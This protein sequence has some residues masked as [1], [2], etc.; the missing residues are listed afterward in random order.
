MDGSKQGGSRHEAL[1]L[2]RFGD[3][4]RSAQSL[5]S[6]ENP[7][8]PLMRTRHERREDPG[9]ML[10]PE[11]GE[12]PKLGSWVLPFTLNSMQHFSTESGHS[13]VKTQMPLIGLA[14]DSCDLPSSETGRA[15]CSRAVRTVDSRL[16][17]ANAVGLC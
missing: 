9:L 1:P 5:V 2:G 8:I 12:C 14:C 4:V 17:C 3:W 15:R 16:R 7:S 11:G 10:N 13:V 6:P